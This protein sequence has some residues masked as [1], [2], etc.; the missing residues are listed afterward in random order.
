MKRFTNVFR[1][2]SKYKALLLTIIITAL[3]YGLYKDK[4]YKYSKAL[5]SYC[6]SIFM[7]SV[8]CPGIINKIKSVFQLIKVI[9]STP[10]R[11]IRYKI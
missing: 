9:P 2:D 10:W 6:A 1:S 5:D 11:L 8:K 3:S 4:W 7:L